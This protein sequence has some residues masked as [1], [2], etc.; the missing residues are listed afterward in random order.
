MAELVLG[1]DK[2]L[3]KN[4]ME[5]WGLRPN[6]MSSPHKTKKKKRRNS[7][8]LREYDSSGSKKVRFNL[9]TG[10][11]PSMANSP[12]KISVIKEHHHKMKAGVPGNPASLDSMNEDDEISDIHSEEHPP[13][14]LRYSGDMPIYSKK[15]KED[16]LRV[17]NVKRT[18]VKEF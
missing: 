7:A 12:T 10:D 1:T 4:M 3:F 9:V 8:R 16:M 17:Y 18:E 15:H 5:W 13:R 6:Q 2:K 11:T 14:V